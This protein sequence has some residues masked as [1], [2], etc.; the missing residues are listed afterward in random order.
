MALLLDTCALIWLVN[1]DEM[2]AASLAAI[3]QAYA[4][5]DDLRYSPISAW[6]VGMLVARGRLMLTRPVPAWFFGFTSQPGVRELPLTNDIL[7]E[8]SF[9]PGQPPAD[10]ADR[11]VIA[12]ARAEDLTIVTRDRKILAYGEAGH[13]RILPC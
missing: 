2:S 5:G 4:D 7:I 13:A 11:M 8:S 3:D 12:G 6:E 9:L 1:G 10:P